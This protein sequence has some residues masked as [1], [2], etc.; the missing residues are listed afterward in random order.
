MDYAHGCALLNM[1]L[2]MYLIRRTRDVKLKILNTLDNKP[3][4]EDVGYWRK[5]NQIHR[6]F[7]I[8]VQ[9]KKDDCN[10]YEVSKDKIIELLEICKKVKNHHTDAKELLP[11]A[12][13]FFFGGTDYDNYYFNEITDT[14]KILTKVL[15]ETDFDKQ[16]IFYYSSW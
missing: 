10:F 6:W 15:E 13:G 1:G 9:N 5:A 11:T 3:E 4:D 14:I 16:T 2:D 12:S 7:V 8:N